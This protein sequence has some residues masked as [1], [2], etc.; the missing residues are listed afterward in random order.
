MMTE[1]ERVRE[2]WENED[3]LYSCGYEYIAGVDEAGRG[4][5]IGKYLVSDFPALLVKVG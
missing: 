5:L 4:P 1:E 2:M 3:R